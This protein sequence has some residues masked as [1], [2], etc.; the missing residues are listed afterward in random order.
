VTEQPAGSDPSAGGPVGPAGP[1]CP[2]CR[3][4]LRGQLAQ[5]LITAQ[6]PAAPGTE[7]R[8]AVTYCGH[9]GIALSLVPAG[10]ASGINFAAPAP[11]KVSRPADEQTLDGRFQLRCQQLVGQIRSLGL[12]PHVWVDMINDLGAAG[13]ARKLLADHHILVAT[14]WLVLQGRPELTLEH[15][16]TEPVWHGLF[17]DDERASAAAQLARA[18]QA[19]PAS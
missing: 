1:V 6:D 17:T 9:C 12:D 13:A 15:E 2:G 11:Q 7:R 4:P 19:P 5:E 18:R 14:R 16:V 8:M 10:I 3:R